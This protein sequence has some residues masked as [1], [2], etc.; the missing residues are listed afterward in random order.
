MHALAAG[1]RLGISRS[2]ARTRR[3]NTDYTN[4]LEYNEIVKIK[5]ANSLWNTKLPATAE[6]SASAEWFC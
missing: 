6:G 4:E 2:Q 1:I 3:I 5:G